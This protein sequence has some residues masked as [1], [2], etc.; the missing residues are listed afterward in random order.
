M[1]TALM[2]MPR[3]KVR[4]RFAGRQIQLTNTP[5]VQPKVRQGRQT[6]KSQSEV[7]LELARYSEMATQYASGESSGL[8]FWMASEAGFASVLVVVWSALV[9]KC[10]KA[11]VCR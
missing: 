1:V 11:G 4:H 9:C 10:A 8:R 3:L 5:A 7:V 6:K 2:H